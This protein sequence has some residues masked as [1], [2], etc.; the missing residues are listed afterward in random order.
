MCR[1]EQVIC[2]GVS[3]KARPRTLDQ[4]LKVNL[5]KVCIKSIVHFHKLNYTEIVVMFNFDNHLLVSTSFMF[6]WKGFL[7]RLARDVFFFLY[8]KDW[9]RGLKGE[10]SL[11][12]SHEF[13][14]LFLG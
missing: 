2:Q 3:I 1:G 6:F 5:P 8:L 13:E 10:V 14:S 4:I 7:T 11:V 12:M 9:T